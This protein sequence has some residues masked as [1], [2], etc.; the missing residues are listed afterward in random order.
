VYW[1][2]IAPGDVLWIDLDVRQVA[3]AGL[4]LCQFA[5][6]GGKPWCGVRRF[7]LHN[8]GKQAFDHSGRGNFMPLSDYEA[9]RMKVLGRVE[10][11]FKPAH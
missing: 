8:N 11:V 4:Y 3:G 7:K 6:A 1:P 5:G 9:G 10:Q 2:T